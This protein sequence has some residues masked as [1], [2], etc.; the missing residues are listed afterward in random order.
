MRPNLIFLFIHHLIILIIFSIVVVKCD[1]ENEWQEECH[2]NCV[3]FKEANGLKSVE[4]DEIGSLTIPSGLH[5]KIEILDLR[6]NPIKS[7]E[8]EIFLNKGL[9]NLKI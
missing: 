4:C 1:D 7:L 6:R 8:N 5:S 3:C 2:E 9:I